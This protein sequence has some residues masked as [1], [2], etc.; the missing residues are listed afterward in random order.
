MSKI[1]R[2]LITGAGGMLGSAVVP[3][4]KGKGLTVLSTSRRKNSEVVDEV[5]DVDDFEV[6][7][8]YTNKFKP[9]IILHL[10]AETDLEL[11]EKNPDRAYTTN[12]IGAQNGAVLA[13]Q[14][15]IPIVEISSAGIFDGT[16]IDPYKDFDTPAPI[17]VYGNSKWQGEKY[18]TNHC[19]KYF[20]AR[21]GWMVGGGAKDKKFVSHIVN[22]IIDG[23]TELFGLT[24][25]LGAPTFAPDFASNLFELVQTPFYGTYNMVCEGNISRFD[26]LEE[27]VK[28]L[29]LEDRI[30]V[31]KVSGDYFDD[32][33]F[34][35]RPRSE[36][37]EN[38]L[39]RLRNLNRM[40]D[41]KTA[42]T[43]YV[44]ELYASRSKD[45]TAHS[46]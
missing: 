1:N 37:L 28:M 7:S 41:W 23:K 38:Y 10:A 11:C 26:I 27:I 43:P 13:I 44:Q 12:T 29:Q 2:V 35:P 33:F 5:L 39:L 22:Q 6:Y 46:K 18:I 21:A 20:I 32:Q 30:K 31:T 40:R 34:A 8:S 42:L 14:C 9:D 25:K 45:K 3:Y 24:D 19:P 17:N 15:D 4:F 36:V 16:K